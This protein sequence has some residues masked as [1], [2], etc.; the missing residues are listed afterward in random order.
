[1]ARFS[2][3]N[4]SPRRVFVLATGERVNG[5]GEINAIAVALVRWSGTEVVDGYAPAAGRPHHRLPLFGHGRSIGRQPSK[6]I[7]ERDT[8]TVHVP[9]SVLRAPNER[10]LSTRLEI[11]R[12]AI[13]ESRRA[14][15]WSSGSIT[16]DVDRRSAF[17]EN[18][19]H[20]ISDLYVATKR[21]RLYDDKTISRCC[22]GDV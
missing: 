19:R 7:Q 6:P 14:I 3:A 11:L 2:C 16:A 10:V 13:E 5:N 12:L 8:S 17:G 4:C 18:Q 21:Y 22:N 20:P 9:R 1:M 15:D